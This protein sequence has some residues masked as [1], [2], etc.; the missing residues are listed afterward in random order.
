MSKGDSAASSELPEFVLRDSEALGLKP[1]KETP[2][3]FVSA[4]VDSHVHRN[5]RRS[6]HALETKRLLLFDPRKRDR[7][8]RGEEGS[9]K[10]TSCAYR[11]LSSREKKRRK[12]ND[13]FL[14]ECTRYDDFVPL[15]KLWL[16]YMKDL[17]EIRSDSKGGGQMLSKLAKA[18]FHGCKMTV[19]KSKCPHYVG[20]TG[21]IIMETQNTF[22]VIT[23][24]NTIKVVP[25]SGSVFAFCIDT[26][27]FNL[28]GSQLCYRAAERSAR[29]FKLKPTKDDV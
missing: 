14:R 12:T 10:R 25:K 19:S 2:S 17:L 4:F 27:L 20:L 21:I 6:V 11:P 29:K 13:A 28:H 8:K 15:H 9:A 24:E 3:G 22:K 5:K 23:K 1:L 26:F 16:Q 18:D 7:R